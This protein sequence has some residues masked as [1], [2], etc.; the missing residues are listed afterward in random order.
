M[1][2]FGCL[3]S[4]IIPVY[5]VEPYLREALDSVIHQT[6]SNLEIIIID[7]GST[8]SSKSIC[9][10][11]AKKDGRIT[12]VHTNNNGLSSARNR[13]LRLFTGEVVTFLDSDDAFRLDFISTMLHAMIRSNADI[14]LCKYTVH[15][16]TSKMEQTNE[17]K[18]F[19]LS[20]EG[21]FNRKEA[22][23]ALAENRI[24]TASWNK[25]YLGRLWKDIQFPE[26]H[27]YE[28]VDTTYRII[29]ASAT[30]LVVD[31]PLYLYRVRLGSISNTVSIRYF[32]DLFL[33]RSHF[34]SF[35]KDNTPRV[36]SQ[37]HEDKWRR[38]RQ[39][40]FRNMI[41]IYYCSVVKD[42]KVNDLAEAKAQI[43]QSGKEIGIETCSISTRLA[44]YLIRYC[45]LLLRIAYPAYH[46][47]RNIQ[48][49]VLGGFGK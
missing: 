37:E 45:P 25:L 35:I 42:R 40:C 5:N 13:G 10:D 27:V 28:D 23:R 29:N 49:K 19:P 30:V 16:T 46:R 3:V 6:Y 34:Y 4:V 11:Y 20:E 26:D 48:R 12:I 21:V 2:Y 1:M 36:F 39:D 31:E 47:I 17:Q 38:M 7:D 43:I 15:D 22:L 24:N 9:D 41:S 8:D 18:T 14:V 32:R 44:Y 33:A